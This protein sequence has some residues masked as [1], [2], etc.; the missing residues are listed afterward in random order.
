MHPFQQEREIASS[1]DEKALAISQNDPV[2]TSLSEM[3]VIL[4]S[5]RKV[6]CLV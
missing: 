3:P 4:Y 1:M 6:I 2:K 5:N